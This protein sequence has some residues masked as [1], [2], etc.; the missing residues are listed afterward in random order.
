MYQVKISPVGCL[1]PVCQYT[2][3]DLAHLM[4]SLLDLDNFC[5]YIDELRPCRRV[6]VSV[7]VRDETKQ[8]RPLKCIFDADVST[9]PE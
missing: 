4:S 2:C 5:Q 8:F 9:F 3:Y 6:N 1:E 7:Y